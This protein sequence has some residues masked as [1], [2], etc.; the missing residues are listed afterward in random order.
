MG[1][2]VQ[3]K[4]IVLIVLLLVTSLFVYRQ[5]APGAA[6]KPTG[7]QTLLG[8]VPGYQTIGSVTLD[9]SIISFLDL[10]DYTQIGYNSKDGR[11]LSLYIGYYFTADKVSAAHSPLVCFPGQGWSLTT[12]GAGQL[13]VGEHFVKYAEMTATLEDR[14]ELVFYWYQA[15]DKTETE[16]YRNKLNTML[17]QITAGRQEHAFVRVTVPILEAGPE[18]ARRVG[19]AFISAFYPIFLGYIDSTPQRVQ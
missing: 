19:L 10:D 3:G 12:P 18:E 4:I 7:L 2:K 14:K 17:N 8:P 16:I 11:A 15:Y 5:K 13:Q 9:P 1:K 6:A